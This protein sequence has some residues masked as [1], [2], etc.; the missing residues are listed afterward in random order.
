MI[1]GQ[2]LGGV[3][4]QLGGVLLGVVDS[5]SVAWSINP[6]GVQGWDSAD[7]RATLTDRQQDHGSWF[8][9]VYLGSRPITLTGTI[10]A[11]SAA[12]L[13]AAF[14]QLLSACS[15]TDTTLIVNDSI[16]R[17][18]TV[19]RSGKPVLVKVTDRIATY[20]LLVTAG[21]PRRYST[22]LNQLSTALPSISG[23]LSLP[24]T[25][26]LA[27]SATTVAGS[28]AALNSGSF[29][30]R[31]VFTISGPVSQP[32]VATLYPDGTVKALSYTGADLA[33]GDQLVIDTDAHTV[34]QGGASR[35]RWI[36]G[37]WPDIP[38]GVQVQFQ[39]RAA[40]YNANALLTATWRSAWI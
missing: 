16:P 24:A 3:T 33:A 11:P 37:A 14:E 35:R 38:A 22:T 27:L 1:P 7:V 20:S 17:Q 15:L 9:P 18:A 19:R 39:F 26:P 4:V 5:N 36:S 10:T 12:L 32:V 28:I 34:Q 40:T 6:D 8:A 30:T 29:A 23:G 13:D 31:P 2:V 21:D 25:A